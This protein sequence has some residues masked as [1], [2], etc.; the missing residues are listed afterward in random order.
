[1][2]YARRVPLVKQLSQTECGLCCCAMILRYYYSK[3][4][5]KELQE[6]IIV[7]RDGMSASNVKDFFLKRGFDSSIYKVFDIEGLKEIKDPFISLWQNKHYVVVEKFYKNMW[8]IKDPAEGTKVI[9]DELFKEDFSGIVVT[10]KPTQNFQPQK[11]KKYNPW[12][13]TLHLLYGCKKLLLQLILLLMLTYGLT[14][15]VSLLIQKI[16]DISDI[17]ESASYLKMFQII[18]VLFCGIYFSS[19]ITRGLKL[20]TLNVALGRSLEADT[21]KN[22]LHLKYNFFEMRTSG[23]LL[24]RLNSTSGVKELISSQIL[25]GIIDIGNTVVILYYMFQKSIILAVVS[26][27]IFVINY[28][29]MMIIQPKLSLAQYTENKTKNH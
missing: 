16:I 6:E 1:M 26:V 23:D 27:A 14:L 28:E 17:S 20:V 22:L 5:L 19:V 9:S 25:N 8:Y 12:L 11:K 15:G 3:E 29:I 18:T 21:F 4:T 13:D 7:G 24:F 2:K 10:V